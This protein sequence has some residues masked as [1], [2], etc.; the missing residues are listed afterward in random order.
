MHLCLT[1]ECIA[2]ICSV[3]V[4]HVCLSQFNNVSPPLWTTCPRS[5]GL[6]S[7]TELHIPRVGHPP[8]SDNRRVMVGVGPHPPLPPTEPPP[9]ALCP[10]SPPRFRALQI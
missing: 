3:A 2:S 7:G 9:L 10:P 6:V 8:E 1:V 4:L 5:R